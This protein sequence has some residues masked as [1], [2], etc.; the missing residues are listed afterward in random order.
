MINRRNERIKWDASSGVR[1]RIVGG[2][3]GFDVVRLI[4]IILD[5]A[6][7]MTT[8]IRDTRLVTDVSFF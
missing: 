5:L 4:S 7:L 2:C 6:W 1:S 3:D 8:L